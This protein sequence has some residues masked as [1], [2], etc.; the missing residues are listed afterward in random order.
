[1][2]VSSGEW[3]GGRGAIHYGRPSMRMT[4][5]H[6]RAHLRALQVGVL[7][8]VGSSPTPGW[9]PTLRSRL[10]A[11]TAAG[12]APWLK[13]HGAGAAIIDTPPGVRMWPERASA[14]LLDAFWQGTPGC[15]P[16]S[17]ASRNGLA[18]IT[19]GAPHSARHLAYRPRDLGQVI[20]LHGLLRCAR[21]RSLD[22]GEPQDW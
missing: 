22:I 5:L 21:S 14:S 4:R 9:P 3:H 16:A 12:N 1:M 6:G 13:Q 10:P 2:G 20:V 15:R 7:P 8:K 17:T 19:H 11:E 18:G